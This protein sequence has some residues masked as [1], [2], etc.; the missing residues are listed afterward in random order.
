MSSSRTLHPS[1]SRSSR[2]ASLPPRR[3]D[4]E[5]TARAYSP[6]QAR[7]M[8]GLSAE[9][10]L[11][12][13]LLTATVDSRHCFMLLTWGFRTMS[14]Q[15]APSATAIRP[16]RSPMSGDE[17]T[18]VSPRSEAS[19]ESPAWSPFCEQTMVS[20]PGTPSTAVPM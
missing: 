17:I 2:T 20:A 1:G 8:I 3:M 12:A 9:G 13:S 6:D 5:A 10:S 11:N 19:L 15:P 4:T 18:T 14:L 16:I 7:T